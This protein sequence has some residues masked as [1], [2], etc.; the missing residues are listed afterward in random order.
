VEQRLQVPD[1]AFARGLSH[2]TGLFLTVGLS[3]QKV[4]Q[5]QFPKSLLNNS[6]SIHEDLEATKM[7]LYIY[8]RNITW[9]D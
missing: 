7:H 8:N 4:N 6:V 2:G 3:W 5:H 9:I 1:S